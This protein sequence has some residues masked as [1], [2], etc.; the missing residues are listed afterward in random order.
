M[1]KIKGIIK[2]IIMGNW[3]ECE[4]GIYIPGIWMPGMW[5][6]RKYW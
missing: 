1:K 3:P 5:F 2:A 6:I 4:L